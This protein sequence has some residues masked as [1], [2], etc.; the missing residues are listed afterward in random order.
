[1]LS[2]KKNKNLRNNNV[3]IIKIILFNDNKSCEE[4]GIFKRVK[5]FLNK[6]C[7]HLN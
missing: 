7:R 4:I 5:T 3:K 1:M 6:E 2:F